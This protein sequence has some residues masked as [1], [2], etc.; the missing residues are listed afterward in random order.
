MN[1]KLK[2]I[3][4][5]LV[6][7]ATLTACGYNVPSDM[8]AVHEGAGPFE[9]KKIKGCKDPADRG[10]WT[11]DKYVLLPGPSNQRVW[12]MTGQDGS[13]AKPVESSSKDSVV[14]QVPISVR[15]NLKGDC[16]TLTKFYTNHVRRSGV[17][18][19][20]NG[21][22]N[23]KWPALLRSIVGDP[24]DQTLDRI[25]KDYNWRD[26]TYDPN[27][28]AEIER[29]VDEQLSKEGTSLLTQA[30]N[31]SYFTGISVIVGSPKPANDDLK[32]AVAAEQTKVAEARSA[33]AQAK[34]DEQKAKA[35]V[36]VA[37][38][39]AAKKAAEIAGYPSVEEY[40]KAKAIEKGLNPYQPT[41]IVNGT[42]N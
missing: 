39:E 1:R 32:N 38:A 16:E 23:D 14:M 29:K 19:K 4:L 17:E 24:V 10:F 18:F 6:G 35:Q 31:G 9:A 15:F 37:Q 7:V 42:N 12:D 28:R 20:D 11:N 3:A 2:S 40:N 8:V 13:D 22:Y 26:L 34:A 25:V 21:D 30:A 5:A 27:L 33:E 36:A 41:Y